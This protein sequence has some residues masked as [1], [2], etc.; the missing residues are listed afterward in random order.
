MEGFHN[1]RTAALSQE[2]QAGVAGRRWNAARW[3][4]WWWRS[5]SERIQLGLNDLQLEHRETA[6][7]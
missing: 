2:R 7:D 5:S 1:K 4:W 3:R 6:D